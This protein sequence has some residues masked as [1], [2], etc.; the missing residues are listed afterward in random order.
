MT[1]VADKNRMIDCFA[2]KVYE[3][4][5][6]LHILGP[7]A[8]TPEE[9]FAELAAIASQLESEMD[10]FRCFRILSQKDGDKRVV[11]SKIILPQLRA[12]KKMFNDL[13]KEGM[14]PYIV[15][16][17]GKASSRV[18]K[19]FDPTAEEVIFIPVQAI[20]GG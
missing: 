17:D 16:V 2:K 4:P 18:M 10:D 20:R 9:N 13:I 19:E 12:A 3:V 14:V 6:V 1:T 5:S 15:G 7:N 8:G 11:W